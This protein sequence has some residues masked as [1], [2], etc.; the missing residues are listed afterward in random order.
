M[1]GTTYRPVSSTVAPEL[2]LP[3]SATGRPGIGRAGRTP[4]PIAAKRVLGF[5]VGVPG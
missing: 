2:K 5:I 3:I 1:T 4:P